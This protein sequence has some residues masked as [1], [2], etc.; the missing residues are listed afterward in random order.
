MPLDPDLN[1][2]TTASQS[3]AT[4][5]FVDINEGTGTVLYYLTIQAT[6]GGAT[7]ALKRDI[8]SSGGVQANMALTHGN[9]YNVDILF[10]TPKTVTGTATISAEL[11]KAGNNMNMTITFKKVS[12]ATTSISSA[13]VS[14]TGDADG[15]IFNVPVPLT[16][17]VF[18][19]GDTLRVT[20]TPSGVGSKIWADP[21]A[22][23]GLPFKVL[24]P[25]KLDL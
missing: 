3:V 6:S 9:T 23:T 25:F 4:Y 12:A 7:Y 21:S 13:I 5:D 14:P 20:I 22:S 15:Y 1:E 19:A 16:E 18:A 10:N 17:T 11:E 8:L 2:F 24:V